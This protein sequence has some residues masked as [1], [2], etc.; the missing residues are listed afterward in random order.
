MVNLHGMADEPIKERQIK[1]EEQIRKEEEKRTT[2]SQTF[3][4]NIVRWLYMAFNIVFS[5]HGGALENFI[6]VPENTRNNK[7]KKNIIHRI[8]V[9]NV[10]VMV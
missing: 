6:P 2:K 1:E 5:G 10:V 3:R 9:F 7:K 8:I 4:E